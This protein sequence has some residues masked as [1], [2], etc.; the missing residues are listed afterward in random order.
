MSIITF[1]C[2]CEVDTS[3]GWGKIKHCPLHG[4]APDLL[5]ACKETIAM[6]ARRRI[7]HRATDG[8]GRESGGRPLMSKPKLY[9]GVQPYDGELNAGTDED[10]HV[11]YTDDLDGFAE[12][13]SERATGADA[14]DAAELVRR[15][16]AFPDLL[17]AC[18]LAFAVFD[19]EWSGRKDAPT[20]TQKMDAAQALLTAI[21][22]AEGKP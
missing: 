4:A 18:K 12:C 21:T 13:I 14:A 1:G 10:G 15:W 20:T 9:K 16:N 8:G 17:V 7:A 22:K 19:G 11:T 5:A 3:V 2:G 6:F